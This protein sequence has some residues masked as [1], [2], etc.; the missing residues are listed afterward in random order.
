[1]NVMPWKGKTA[2][3]RIF[4]GVALSESEINSYAQMTVA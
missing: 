1:M 4:K 3:L 2:D